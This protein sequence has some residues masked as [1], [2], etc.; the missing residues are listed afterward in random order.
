MAVLFTVTPYPILLIGRLALPK[1]G[2]LLVRQRYYA[3]VVAFAV[4]AVP[5]KVLQATA[6]AHGGA[7]IMS[8][9]QRLSAAY[10]CVVGA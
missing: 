10:G 4:G 9:P 1:R 5:H 3:R 2:R 7:K 8:A 6:A